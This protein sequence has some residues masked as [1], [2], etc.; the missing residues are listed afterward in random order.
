MTKRLTAPPPCAETMYPRITPSPTCGIDPGPACTAGSPIAWISTTSCCAICAPYLRPVSICSAVGGV[1]GAL[2]WPLIEELAG[3]SAGAATKLYTQIWLGRAS[4]G[5]LIGVCWVTLVEAHPATTTRAN[6]PITIRLK[7]FIAN[8]LCV[9]DR[10]FT[11][12]LPCV[13]QALPCQ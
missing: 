7:D 8:L 5:P 1:L 9:A 13:S 6:R 10:G 11:K 2:I 3:M 12:P 4:P